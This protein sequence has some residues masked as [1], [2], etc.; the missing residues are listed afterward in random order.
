MVIRIDRDDHEAAAGQ[1]HREGR[2]RLLAAFE[3]RADEYRR[4]GL[5]TGGGG[6]TKEVGRDPLAVDRIKP[7]VC[8][9][10]VT[11]VGL[12]QMAG[13]TPAEDHQQGQQQ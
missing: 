13:Q 8:D 12:K 1:L 3:A 11:S 7:E 6:R 9:F 2:H 4:G 5:F 10:D